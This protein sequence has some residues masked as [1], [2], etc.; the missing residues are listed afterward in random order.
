MPV[1]QQP[2]ESTRCLQTVSPV[3]GSIYVERPYIESR[4]LA[5]LISAAQKAQDAWQSVELAQRL[6][7]IER[8][9]ELFEADADRLA[10]EISWQ[11][12]RPAHQARGEINGVLERSRYM[13]SIAEQSLA[14]DIIEDTDQ[15]KRYIRHQ[16]LGVVLLIAP[17]NY[18]YL[19]AINTLVPALLAGNSVLLKHSSQTP[20]CGERLEEHLLKAGLPLGLCQNLILTHEQTEQL[21]QHPAVN[22]VAFTGSVRGG[23]QIQEAASKR[24]INTGLELGGTDP[25]YV[26]ADADLEQS[27][28][29]LVDGAFFNA[30]QSCCGV[31][32]IYVDEKVFRAFVTGF[33]E[34]TKAYQLGNPLDAQTTMGPMVRERAADWVRQQVEDAKAAGAKTLINHKS[35][36]D[37]APNYLYPEVLIGVNHKMSI[38]RDESFGP[39]VGIMSVADDAEAFHWMSDSDFGLTASIWT[40]DRNVAE[41]MGQQLE[42]GTCFMNRCDYLDPAL[43]WAGVKQ[44]GKGV[45]LSRLGYAQLTR[46]Q[47]FYLSL[48]Q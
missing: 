14:D 19:T 31:E 32:R 10:E 21:V 29:G 24:F 42:T 22:F 44:S 12:G 1:T 11:M 46:P 17:W 23:E 37:F 48:K 4:A 3:D 20:V 13:L 34:K 33:V 8:F 26:R 2:R 38:M 9:L 45:S 18:P 7:C 35:E 28:E 41:R 47:S 5:H 43:A 15:H 36:N 40:G 27:I 30:G 39:V 16:P 25:A 6:A